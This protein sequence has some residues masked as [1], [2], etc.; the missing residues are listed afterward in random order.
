M[1]T[2]SN[3]PAATDSTRHTF[4]AA[5]GGVSTSVLAGCLAVG[6]GSGG[7]ETGTETATESDTPP[8]GSMAAHFSPDLAKWVDE[9]PRPVVAE[10][11]RTEDGDPHY[12]IEMRAVEQK[13][14]RDLPPTTVFGYDGRYP[15]PTIEARRGDPVSVRWKN[16]LPDEHILPVD[17]TVKAEKAPYDSDGVWAVTHLHGGNIAPESDGQGGM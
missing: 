10:P 12:E 6:D 15:G 14:H 7:A 9:V 1:T 2:P 13:L 17:T 4:L 16:D 8:T 11:S 3:D 5:L